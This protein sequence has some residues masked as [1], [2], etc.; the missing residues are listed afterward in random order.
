MMLLV[1]LPA[2]SVMTSPGTAW[3]IA[4]DSA[5]TDATDTD[6]GARPPSGAAALTA[7]GAAPGTCAAMLGQAMASGTAVTAA[8][9][10]P[11]TSFRRVLR[12][13]DCLRSRSTG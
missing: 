11:S 8:H 5:W 12:S 6:W 10:A 7:A 13:M 4:V 3:A 1:Y 2:A 9:T